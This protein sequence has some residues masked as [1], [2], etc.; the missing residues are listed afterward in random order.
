MD[1]ERIAALVIKRLS[2][3]LNAAEEAELQSWMS[4]SEPRRQAV[5]PFL[6]EAIVQQRLA[7]IHDMKERVWDKLERVMDEGKVIPMQ[8]K[9]WWK[10]AAAA[11]I[12]LLLG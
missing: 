3:E 1:I 8:G 4:A 2:G 5:E 10:W 9:R 11:S 6:D 7:K 12:I